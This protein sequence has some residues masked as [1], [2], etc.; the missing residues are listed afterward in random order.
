MPICFNELASES[1]PIN[2]HF[3]LESQPMDSGLVPWTYIGLKQHNSKQAFPYI[4]LTLSRT[5][6]C[7][8]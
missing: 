4:L 2:D 3:M 7:F 5:E 1:Q 6:I 8:A